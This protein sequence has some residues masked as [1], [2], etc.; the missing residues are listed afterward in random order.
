MSQNASTAKGW[1]LVVL[2]TLAR[3]YNRQFIY[4]PILLSFIGVAEFGLY[5][6]LASI[7]AYFNV[8]DFRL[9]FND[10]P[11]LVKCKTLQDQEKI[12]KLLTMSPHPI[13]R[14]WRFT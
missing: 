4:V 5:R 10:Y 9:I 8:L 11:I 2:C 6:L 12:D 13:C 14:D 3:Q 1:Y 7:I